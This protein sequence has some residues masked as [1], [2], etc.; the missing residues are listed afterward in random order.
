MMYHKGPCKLAKASVFSSSPKYKQIKYDV[1]TI[2]KSMK[3]KK[4]K[5]SLRCTVTKN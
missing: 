1:S 3:Y 5:N 4:P 2:G